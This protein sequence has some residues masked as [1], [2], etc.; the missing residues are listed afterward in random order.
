MI[1]SAVGRPHLTYC[2]NIHP[3]ES[4]PQIRGNLERYVLRVKEK[5][6]P[7]EPFGVGLRLSAHAAEALR[8]PEELEA[9]REFLDTHN[10]YVFTINGF[11]YGDFHGT[12]VKEQVYVPDWRQE[13]R[14]AYTDTLAYVLARLLPPEPEVTGSI[15][16]V[17]GGFKSWIGTEEDIQ[18]MVNGLVRHAATLHHLHERTGRVITLALEP[19]PH[20]FLETIA[21]TT[22][23]FQNYLFGASAVEDFSRLSGLNRAGSEQALRRHLGVCFDACHAAVEFE[24]PVHSIEVLRSAGIRIAKLQISAGIRIPKLAPIMLDVLP[25]FSEEVYLHQVVER[26]N[27]V[28]TSYLDLPDALSD[29]R[30]AVK[31]NCEWRIHF[32]VP[33]FLKHIG[34]FE[35]TQEFLERILALQASTP[36]TDHL[37]VETYTWK[38]LPEGY[39]EMDI[40]SAITR[41]LT[42][43]IERMAK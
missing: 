4:W 7:S 33:I 17:P 43:V 19:E 26:C 29:A 36:F 27:G 6:A 9:F 25:A 28:Q 1:L 31:P 20:G 16:T 41:E 12:R 30:G 39:L 38:V 42:W 11:P 10:L 14:L 23:F 32:H 15:S 2:T 5:I 13:E 18:R 24:D 34:V 37:E 40:V 3:G 22:V 35:N 21:G 8:H